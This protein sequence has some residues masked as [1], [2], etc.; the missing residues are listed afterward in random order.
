MR[1]IVVG[2]GGHGQVVADALLACRQ[3][4]SSDVQ[5]L[6]F[7]DENEDMQGASLSSVTVL[8]PIRPALSYPHDAVVVAVGNN[9]ARGGLMRALAAQG[10][11]FYTVVHPS[12]VVAPDVVIGP[13]SVVLAGAVINTGSCLGTGVIV[14]TCA[15]VD[16]HSRVSAYAHIGPG[17][18]TGGNISVGEGAF[19]GIGATV[20]PQRIIGAW[21]K[22]GAGATV[23]HDV[24][25]RATVVGTPARI[26]RYQEEL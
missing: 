22:V 21:A 3:S 13:G 2:A 10:E 26:V 12:A 19:V 18:H 17:A 7:A 11:S 16:H 6:G 14:N 1:I 20:L 5:L 8:G 15:S 9:R 24:P 4:S 25:D 23:I